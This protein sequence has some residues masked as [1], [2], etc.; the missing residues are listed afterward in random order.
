MVQ[1]KALDR[2]KAKVLD[3]VVEYTAAEDGAK[4]AVERAR[5]AIEVVKRKSARAKVRI[6]SPLRGFFQH[7]DFHFSYSKAQKS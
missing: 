2:A 4:A 6:G 3:A 7:V 1:A 5:D